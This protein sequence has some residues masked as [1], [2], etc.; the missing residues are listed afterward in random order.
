MTEIA[1]QPRPKRRRTIRSVDRALTILTILSDA[2]DEMPL[3]EI[4]FRTGLNVS[5]C[6]H[7][8]STLHDHGYV[9]QNPRGRAYFL[10]AQVLA[11]S[12]KRARQFNLVDAAMPELR[13][14]ASETSETAHLTVLQGTDLATLI[15]L[16]SVQPVRAGS[17][18]PVKRQAVHA[19]ASGKSILAGLADAEIDR[20][21]GENGLARFTDA[22]HA[23]LDELM[24]DL[25][26]VRK[27]GVAHDREEFEPGVTCV[28]SAVRD[29]RGTA[30]AAITCSMPAIRATQERLDFLAGC[31]LLRARN[32]SASLG[33]SHLAV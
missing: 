22:T 17:D 3:N 10:G 29:H 27:T 28:G 8:L 5:T 20:I 16:D 26:A 1:T 18:S 11:L 9:A 13:K 23:T 4:A 25:R 30:V 7:L 32:I 12:V 2:G 24:D 15:K 19:T 6:H 33:A 21:V 31:V 14:L